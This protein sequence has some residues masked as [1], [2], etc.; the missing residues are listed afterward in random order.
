MKKLFITLFFLSFVS[1]AKANTCSDGIAENMH[2]YLRTNI[3]SI[4]WLDV[5]KSACK[6]VIRYYPC[7]SQNQLI[8]MLPKT[9]ERTAPACVLQNQ[10]VNRKTEG[11]CSLENIRLVCKTV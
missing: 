10:G 1:L 3:T 9:I 6:F 7:S 8:S 11:Y 5:N 4:S 2:D